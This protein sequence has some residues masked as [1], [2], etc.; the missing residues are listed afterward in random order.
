MI[1]TKTRKTRCLR[2]FTVITAPLCHRQSRSWRSRRDWPALRGVDTSFVRLFRK[3]RI[4]SGTR[5]YTSSS[6]TSGPSRFQV[7]FSRYRVNPGTK[8]KARRGSNPRF[9]TEGFDRP[10]SGCPG[11]RPPPSSA[12]PLPASSG[13]FWPLPGLFR[14]SLDLTQ[15]SHG[16]RGPR[17]RDIQV[18]MMRSL[19]RFCSR[20]DIRRRS[21]LVRPF[22]PRSSG[23]RMSGC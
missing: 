2:N 13:L 20:R 3:P 11:A 22:L 4:G 17:T 8:R 6:T 21:S 19:R 18:V 9:P 23:S 15:D 1:G 5:L 7:G 10:T 16:A 12:R 14:L